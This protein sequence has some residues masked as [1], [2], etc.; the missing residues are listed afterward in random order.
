MTDRPKHNCISPGHS[1]SSS[2]LLRHPPALLAYCC[3]HKC[4]LNA[5]PRQL[6][7]IYSPKTDLLTYGR[8]QN[9]HSRTTANVYLLTFVIRTRWTAHFIRYNKKKKKTFSIFSRMEVSE[10][11]N[12]FQSIPCRLYTIEILSKSTL[13]FIVAKYWIFRKRIPI[14]CAYEEGT[15]GSDP[16]PH[17]PWDF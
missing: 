9:K 16:L 5:M 13:Q 2:A 8:I 12:F 14:G 4:Y 6:I 1:F 17:R 7:I 11:S 10:E 3:G 15:W